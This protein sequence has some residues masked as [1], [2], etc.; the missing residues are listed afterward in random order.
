VTRRRTTMVKVVG[1]LL[2]AMLILSFT[3]PLVAWLR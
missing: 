2:V 1:L 3:L